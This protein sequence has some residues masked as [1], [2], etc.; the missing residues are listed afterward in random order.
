[1]A[2]MRVL[3]TEQRDAWMDVLRTPLHHDVYHLPDYHAIG[4]AHGEGTARLFVYTD[5]P[6]TIAL[7]LLVRALAGWPGLAGGGTNWHDA[8]SVY[9]Y[10]GPIASH[11]GIPAR[12]QEDFHAALRGALADARIVAVFSRLHPLLPQTRLLEG[13]GATPASGQTVSIDLTQPPEVQ[14]AAYRKSHRNS[15][16]RLQRLGVT[17]VEDW[18]AAHLDAFIQIYYETMRRVD[19]AEY[20]FFPCSYFEQLFGR[21]GAT[22]HLFACLQGATFIS[23]GIFTLCDGVAQYHL[24]GTLSAFLPLSP[25]KLLIDTVRLWAHAHGARVLHLGGGTGGAEDSLFWFKAGFSDRRHVFPTWRWIVVPEVYRS[26]CLARAAW[27]EREG[28]DCPSTDY[29]PQYRAPV[30]RA[31]RAALAGG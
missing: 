26:L 28:Y 19:A 6:Y 27:C 23:G 5:G 13:L 17:C 1:M 22:C 18:A 2:T 8:T 9:G 16:V 15:I 31:P 7:P 14:R 30:R 21:L 20:Y 10:A 25:L 24:G 29:F 4:E 11:A 3:G 12:V